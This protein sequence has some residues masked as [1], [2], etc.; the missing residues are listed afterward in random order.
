MTFVGRRRTRDSVDN[1]IRPRVSSTLSQLFSKA[2]RI[3]V[4]PPRLIV[5]DGSSFPQWL[6]QY[7]TNPVTASPTPSFEIRRPSGL[8]PR[9]SSFGSLDPLRSIHH[10]LAVEVGHKRP[11][12]YRRPSASEPNL[13]CFLD[14]QPDT[15]Q[16]THQ[17][18]DPAFE[19][20]TPSTCETRSDSVSML[21]TPSSAYTHHI[22][23]QIWE[24]VMRF[25]PHQ[26]LPSM[27]RVSSDVLLH[28][29]K[30]MYENVDLQSLPPDATRLCIG[31]LALHPELALL[32]L[33]FKS[34][35]L[36]S[37]SDQQGPLPSLSFA[38][39]LRNMKN[40]VSLSLPRFDNVIFHYTTFRL[41]HLSLNCE[42][43]SVL[44]QAH[45]SSWLNTQHHMT[46]LSLFAL[47]TE[48]TH[49]PHGPCIPVQRSSNPDCIGLGR[50]SLPI[51]SSRSLSIPSLRKFDGPISLVHSLVP[52]QP[53]SEVVLH[54]NETLYDGLKPSRL[55]GSI[56]KSTASIERLSIR[57]SP[58]VKIDARTME[59]LLLSA[60]AEFGPSVLYLEVSW[61]TDD[62]SL[63][64]HM[65]SIIP[66]FSNLQTLN[67]VP[68]S[69]SPTAVSLTTANQELLT[70]PVT[71]T[72][73][74]LSFPRKTSSETTAAP[75][76]RSSLPPIPD[77]SASDAARARERQF[78]KSWVK[79]CPSL[80]T[81]T[82]LCGAEWCVIKRR[83]RV[84]VKGA[85]PASVAVNPPMCVPSFVRWRHA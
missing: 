3:S 13:L 9:S 29:R 2:R 12:H 67:C 24:N 80:T 61:A 22:P 36:P 43:M 77:C 81:V 44:E 69:A 35:T 15:Q 60:G 47:T 16:I 78:I 79:A 8:G 4:E 41:Q 59:R 30:I 33:T 63:Y 83:R 38:F 66:R 18:T 28:V 51:P 52:G 42:E 21:S 20:Q 19:N 70:S 40:L 27:A 74:L 23:P 5:S 56:A 73:L 45:F 17:L 14:G 55:M 72:P 46:S 85:I 7:T 37:F 68:V 48:L 71:P 39:A 25:L 65:L 31:S 64:R 32:V 1:K 49:S 11:G 62:E 84:S 82:F 50:L 54:V 57:L 76:L 58:S 75:Q 53:V 34:P 10:A 6:A 26:D